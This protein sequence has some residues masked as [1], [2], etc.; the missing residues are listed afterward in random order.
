[1]SKMRFLKSVVTTLLLTQLVACSSDSDDEQ[2]STGLTAIEQD[3]QDLFEYLQTDYF[4]N[5]ELPSSINLSA[6]ASMPEAMYELRVPD[7]R[8]SFVLTN[9][10]YSDY[11]ASIFF[12]YGFGHRTN[13]SSDGLLIRYVY[14]EGSAAQNGLRRGDTIMEVNGISM[15]DYIAG[16]ATS[17][18]VFGPN[19]DGYT[20]DVTF[21]KPE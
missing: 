9:D 13:D 2:N 21:V 19:E 10:E 1:M 14:T 20:V 15:S 5:E 17:E 11:V 6:Y 4:W 7:D 8:F 3:N 12:G 18:E 16:T